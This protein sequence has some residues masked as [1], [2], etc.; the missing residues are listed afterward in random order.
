M[1]DASFREY[2]ATID[3]DPTEFQRNI[4]DCQSIYLDR[5]GYFDMINANAQ[6]YNYGYNYG[7]Q[8]GY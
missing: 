3:K 1:K 6:G 4:T 8:Y 2:M 5:Q 7:Y